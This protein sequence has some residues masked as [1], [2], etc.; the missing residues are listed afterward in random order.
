MDDMAPHD[1][2]PRRL[3]PF[4]P[5]PT[6]LE[7]PMYAG[8]PRLEPRHLNERGWSLLPGP[9]PVSVDLKTGQMLFH[10]DSSVQV[11]PGGPFWDE[12]GVPDNSREVDATFENE[13]RPS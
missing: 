6:A 8:Q 7:N 10:I 12:H 13:V 2:S 11:V 9:Y 5:G 1:D 3:P 4:E